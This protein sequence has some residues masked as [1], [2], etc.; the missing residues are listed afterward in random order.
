MT[1]FDEAWSLLKMGRRKDSVDI[2]GRRYFTA[3]PNVGQKVSNE[4]PHGKQMQ[5]P[6]PV[7][8]NLMPEMKARLEALKQND[9]EAYQKYLIE[10]SM[11]HTVTYPKEE[12]DAKTP[13]SYMLFQ[14]DEKRMQHGLENPDYYKEEYGD[15]PWS[16]SI[17]NP[18]VSRR[19][20][21]MSSKEIDDEGY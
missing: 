1:A 15:Y 11:G 2:D 8:D 3:N 19:L 9:P 12:N 17:L 18:D 7:V 14:N 10:L 16:D 13:A 6:W 4:N 21:S 5:L 20:Y